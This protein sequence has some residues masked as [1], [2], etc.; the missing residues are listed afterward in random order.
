MQAD[1]GLLVGNAVNPAFS[2]QL[3]NGIKIDK[4]KTE[5]GVSVGADV[6][7]QFTLLPLTA[8]FK[9]LPLQSE[10]VIPY[11]SLNV[12]Y[13][14]NLKEETDER[15]YKGGT[16]V[17]PQ[18]GV[19]INAKEKFKLNIGLGYKQQSATIYQ[20]FENSPVTVITEKYTLG[21]LSLNLG[22]GL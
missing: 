8:S 14:F 20:E 9:W 3:F 17:N 5:A 19:R 15:T 12:G 22:V 10:S 21:R 6:Y 13:A 16:I 4:Y 11:L 1:A 7:N 18:I 2:G